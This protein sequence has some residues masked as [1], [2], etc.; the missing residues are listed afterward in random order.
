M[1]QKVEHDTQRTEAAQAVPKASIDPHK[2][3][4][5]TRVALNDYASRSR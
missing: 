2:C 4:D 1:R 5:S 3:H